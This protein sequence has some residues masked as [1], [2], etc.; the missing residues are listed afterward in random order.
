MP[1]EVAVWTALVML[2]WVL[3]WP[4]WVALQRR[5]VGAEASAVAVELAAFAESLR[6]DNASRPLDPQ[7]QARI[8][9]LRLPELGSFQLAPS[10]P[11]ASPELV[12][13]AATRLALRLKRRV[14]FERKM[15][16]RT[17][18]GRR[19]GAVAGALPPLALIALAMAGADLP[20]ITLVVVALAEALGCWLLSRFA[21]VTP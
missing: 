13:D 18:A 7:L 2:A 15:L 10:L 16:A 8:D 3:A 12:A 1:G 9:R 19:R 21:T 11:N 4:A 6:R 5:R 20:W 14:A 17:A